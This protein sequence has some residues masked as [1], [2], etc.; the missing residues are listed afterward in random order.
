MYFQGLI[1]S[2][3]AGFQEQIT[4]NWRN[5]MTDN[6]LLLAISDMIDKKLKPIHDNLTEIKLLRKTIFFPDCRMWNPAILPPIKDMP[7]ESNIWRRSCRILRF[8]KSSY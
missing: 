8:S 6:E 7:M 2:E 1:I 3:F 5:K 4:D